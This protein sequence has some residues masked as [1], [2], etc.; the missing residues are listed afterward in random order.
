VIYFY[1]SSILGLPGQIPEEE[2]LVPF[3]KADI[4]R[5]GSDV[6]V[7]AIGYMVHMANRVAE[8]LKDSISVEIVDPRTLEPLDIDTIVESVK[9]TGRVV[10]VD[11]DVGRCGPSAEIG[12]QIMEKAFDDL[13][14]PV[15]R[16]ACK[17]YPIPSGYLEDAVLPQPEWIKAAIEGVMGK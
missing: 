6:T 12:M 1:H 4:K 5:E 7:V 11:E 17:N 13:D 16:V 9:K 14:A 3:G 10:I 8:E 2:Y 15:Q